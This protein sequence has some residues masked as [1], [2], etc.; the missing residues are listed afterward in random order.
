[1]GVPGLC[2]HSGGGAQK[3]QP[4]GL[5]RAKADGFWGERA[6]RGCSGVGPHRQRRPAGR[7]RPMCAV[8]SV[9]R[10]TLSSFA[11]LTQLCEVKTWTREVSRLFLS[12]QVPTSF[13]SYD[14]FCQKDLPKNCRRR[15]EQKS[16]LSPRS[17]K[18][19]PTYLSLCLSR[20][21]EER[22]FLYRVFS[23]PRPGFLPL[24]R[25]AVCYCVL[26]KGWTILIHSLVRGGRAVSHLYPFC[27]ENLSSA[28]S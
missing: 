4:F 13:F 15:L 11:S 3:I 6:G 8:K 18:V 20:L 22:F 14:R 24:K 28:K 1:M 5:V 17:E 7:L 26:L 23:H 19:S 16:E 2:F 10:R 25:N 12:R 21:A 27:L 9:R